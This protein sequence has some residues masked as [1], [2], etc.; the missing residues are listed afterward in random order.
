MLKYAKRTSMIY[1]CSLQ[2]ALL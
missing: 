1:P 2:Q